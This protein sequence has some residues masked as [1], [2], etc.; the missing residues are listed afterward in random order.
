MGWRHLG[1]GES[2]RC[3]SLS[4]QD[5]PAGLV[6]GSRQDCRDFVFDTNICA[7]VSSCAS[8]QQ[9][10]IPVWIFFLD[11]MIMIGLQLSVL[12]KKLEC[13]LPL[14]GAARRPK[15][16][17]MIHVSSVPRWV[18]FG[19]SVFLPSKTCTVGNLSQFVIWT[20]EECGGQ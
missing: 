8:V 19:Y 6:A 1:R 16:R 13:S 11:D 10:L 17:I 20:D 7:G 3:L 2:L 9:L 15:V 12:L 4:Q 5:V 18:P 14:S